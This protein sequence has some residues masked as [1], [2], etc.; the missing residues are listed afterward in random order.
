MEKYTVD[1]RT[2]TLDLQHYAARY[3]NVPCFLDLCRQCPNYADSW[4][5]PPFE[6]NPDDILGRYSRITLIA[7]RITP[8]SEGLPIDCARQLILPER[9]RLQR[10]LLAMEKTTGGYALAYAGK[11]THCSEPCT[12]PKGLPC[13]HPHSVRPSLEA[14]GFDLGRTLTDIFGYNLLW[15]NQGKLPPYLTLISALLHN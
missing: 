1:E 8:Q 2:S 13:R 6:Y 10:H 5:C 14:W 9:L 7:T 4:A 15:G 11:C 3:R 12:R